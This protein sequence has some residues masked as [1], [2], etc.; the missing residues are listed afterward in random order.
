MQSDFI[1]DFI[2]HI[3]EYLDVLLEM[4]KPP[5]SDKCQGCQALKPLHLCEDCFIVSYRCATCLVESHKSHPFHRIQAYADN[6]Y[7]G[8][9]LFELGLVL[10]L[11]HGGHPCPNSHGEFT[12]D[13][14]FGPHSANSQRDKAEEESWEDLDPD[15][16]T[17][18]HRD[19]SST[20]PAALDRIVT[21]VDRT[22]VHKHA[23]RFCRCETAE[24]EDMQLLRS[25][26][27][28]ASFRRPQTACTFNSLSD[29][30]IDTV[31][32]KTAPYSYFS[33]L[34]RISDNAFPHDVPV[35]EN[36]LSPCHPS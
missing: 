31:E 20:S 28:P 27:F 24:T 3:P 30:S 8:A 9:S 13:D 15:H 5:S 16:D 12:P 11:G 22:G 36:F 25:K 23:V 21:L 34:R 19:T 29:F 10:S 18:L 1:R 32:C 17:Q 7:R 35:R 4:Y 2:P 26:L 14:L 6:T 33:K